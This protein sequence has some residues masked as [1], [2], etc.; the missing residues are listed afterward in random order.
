MTL[1]KEL[2]GQIIGLRVT[3]VSRR[4]YVGNNIW[5]PCCIRKKNLKPIAKFNHKGNAFIKAVC[6]KE[7]NKC[8]AKRN[9]SFD[10]FKVN[11]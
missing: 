6:L 8:K 3:K 1:G 11:N 2:W 5:K 4:T 7:W 9:T 10:Y